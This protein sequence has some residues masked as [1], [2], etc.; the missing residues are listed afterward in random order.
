MT[1]KIVLGT[2]AAYFLVGSVNAADL[3]DRCVDNVSEHDYQIL[4]KYLATNDAGQY[5]CQ[6]LNRHEFV[7]VSSEN[8]FFCKS[9][10]GVS[11]SCEKDREGYLYPDLTDVKRFRG[12]KGK[13]FVL[14]KTERLS[15]GNYGV[16]FHVFY[17]TPK[18]LNPKGYA[19]FSFPG[20]GAF[21]RSDGEGK[22]ATDDDAGQ[23]ES[24][25][26]VAMSPPFEI[27]NENERN[28]TVRFNQQLVKCKTGETFKQTLEYAWQNG[29]FLKATDHLEKLQIDRRDSD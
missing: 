26:V 13:R 8:F 29:R 4:N 7:Y 21:D 1:L 17:L 15:H 3:L 24:N 11:L 18:S 2:V 28:V 16:G 12:E 20:A 22:C 19:I 23:N 10:S 25:V 6:R 9:I 14:F 27:I 5:L